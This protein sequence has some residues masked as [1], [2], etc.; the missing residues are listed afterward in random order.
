MQLASVH[1]LQLMAACN[2]ENLGQDSV[3]WYQLPASQTQPC[4]RD[5]SQSISIM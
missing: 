4:T 3:P 2:Q 1:R 5:T